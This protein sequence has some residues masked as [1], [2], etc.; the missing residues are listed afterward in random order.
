MDSNYIK[1]LAYSFGADVCGI[2]SIDR[3]K[4]A[5]NGFNPLDIYPEA[6]S[7]I[8]IG[9]HFP[10]SLF[11]ASTKA[12]Y[13]LVKNKSVQLLDDI[14]IKLAFHIEDQ[15]YKAIPIPSDEP[16]EYWDSEN[17]HGRGILSLKH[18]AQACGVGCIGK[19]TLLVNEKYG[20]RLYLGAVITNI[21]LASDA[22]SRNLCIE[23]CNLCLKSCPQSALDGTTIIQKKCRQSCISSTPG[24]GFIYSCYTCREVCPFSKI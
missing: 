9:K 10:A 7:V 18:A 4:D 6:K 13:T 17:K 1:N 14:A 12:P 23:S 3:F 20:N 16:Y 11:A 21:E 2:G 5:P 19:N 15:G 24:G 8:S 22:L